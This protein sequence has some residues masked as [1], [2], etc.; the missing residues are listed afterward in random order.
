MQ[1]ISLA[2]AILALIVAGLALR[3]AQDFHGVV[4]GL[5]KRMVDLAAHVAGRR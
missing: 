5:I 4:D 1:T 3:K 2:V